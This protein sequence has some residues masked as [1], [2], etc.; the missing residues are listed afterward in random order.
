MRHIAIAGCFVLLAGG[1]PAALALAPQPG[2]PVAV[3]AFPWADG[4]AAV[5]IVA[6]AD[7]MLLEAPHDG[8]IAIA[9]SAAA[10]FTARL[11]R[12]GAAL[13]VDGAAVSA[14]LPAMDGH[15][16]KRTAI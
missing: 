12:S 7:G 2:A 9:I 11:Y 5:R 6:A 8:R 16:S 13:V 3:I 14:C 1:M 4:G 15:F 10:D